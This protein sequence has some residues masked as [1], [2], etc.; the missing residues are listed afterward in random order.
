MQTRVVM[1]ESGQVEAID[2]E[3]C[4]AIVR[5]GAVAL[6][7]AQGCRLIQFP[8]GCFYTTDELENKLDTVFAL[9]FQKFIE[10]AKDLDKIR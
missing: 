4:E 2:I 3:M 9:G 1:E 10:I 5:A 8:N 7:A 6:S